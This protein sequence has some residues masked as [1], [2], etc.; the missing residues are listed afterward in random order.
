MK[1]TD[2][3]IVLKIEKLI[4][5]QMT[6]KPSSDCW[7]LASEQLTPLYAEMAIR[8]PNGAKLPADVLEVTKRI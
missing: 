4:E 5:I 6:H 3:E 1:M 7:K 8:Y 2:M